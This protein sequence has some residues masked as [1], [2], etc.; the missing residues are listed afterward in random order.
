M[1]STRARSRRRVEALACA[2]LLAACGRGR[3]SEEPGPPSTTTSSE[4][5]ASASPVDHLAPGELVEGREQA[6]GLMLPR[7]VRV[8]E[9]FVDLVRAEAPVTVHSLVTYFAG[10]LEGGSL[11][12]GAQA[13]TFERV[14]ARGTAGPELLVRIG[15]GLGGAR[16]EIQKVTTPP[17]EPLPDEAARWRRVGLTPNGKLVDPTHLD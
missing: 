15:T 3:S 11:R 5:Q 14:K 17:V 8:K 6:F 4:P 7:D 13:A 12:E 9:S 16:I 10:H 1:T 2:A